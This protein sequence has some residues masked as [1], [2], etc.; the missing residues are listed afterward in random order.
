LVCFFEKID[1]KRSV[2]LTE[3]KEPEGMVEKR[4]K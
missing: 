1:Q 2:Y 4:K 3:K